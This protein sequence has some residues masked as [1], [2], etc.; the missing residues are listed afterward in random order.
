GRRHGRVRPSMATIDPTARIEPGAVLGKDVS[1]GP[2]CVIGPQAVIGDGCRL[3]S[4]VHVSGH[5]T[6]GP[7]SVLY[8]FCSLGTPPQSINY[9]GAPTRV[10]VGAGFRGREGVTIKPGTDD[11]RAMALLLELC[12]LIV[13]HP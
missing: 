13:G 12:F 8:P 2:C 1:I 6:I 11:R 7:R 10:V 4:H 9:R 3:I 5:T